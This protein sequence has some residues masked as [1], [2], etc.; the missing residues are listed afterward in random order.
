MNLQEARAEARRYLDYLKREEAKSLALQRLAADRR[1][2]RCD[3][4]EK[5]R[6]MRDIMGM[7]VKVYDGAELARAVEV[8]LRATEPPVQGS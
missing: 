5:E 8:L 2:G 1:A 6:R 3:D 7:G 4:R